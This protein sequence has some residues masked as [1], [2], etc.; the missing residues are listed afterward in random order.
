MLSSSFSLSRLFK[1]IESLGNI[2]YDG[3]L[4]KLETILSY[5]KVAQAQL[6]W[7]VEVFI[8]YAHFDCSLL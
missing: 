7:S 3:I 5:R 8:C 2:K 4:S 6:Q 1:H